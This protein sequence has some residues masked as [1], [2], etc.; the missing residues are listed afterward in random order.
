M[1]DFDFD[2]AFMRGSRVLVSGD[3]VIEREGA[4]ALVTK[5]LEAAKA[6]I[7]ALAKGQPDAQRF[8]LHD[9]CDII[10]A[11]IPKPP[12]PPDPDP[13]LWTALRAVTTA[14]KRHDA[15]EWCDCCFCAAERVLASKPKEAQP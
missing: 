6:R 13:D 8:A 4:R 12:A 5:A 7:L 9:A 2:K 3:V 14:G 11:L 10:D 15:K 1:T